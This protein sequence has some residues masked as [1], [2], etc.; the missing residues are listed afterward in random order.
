MQ[1]ILLNSDENPKVN[2]VFNKIF[3]LIYKKL[4]DYLLFNLIHSLSVDLRDDLQT[5]LEVAA[6]TMVNEI[7]DKNRFYCKLFS[8]ITLCNPLTRLLIIQ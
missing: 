1:I 7:Y 3:Q 4:I 8:Q 5:V 2:R 6:H